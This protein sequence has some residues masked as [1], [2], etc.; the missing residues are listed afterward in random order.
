MPNIN[1]TDVAAVHHAERIIR[2]QLDRPG[3][4][5]PDDAAEMTVA[6]FTASFERRGGLRRVVLAGGWEVDPAAHVVTP[7]RVPA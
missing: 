5:C 6:G 3:S 7:V 2:D 1:R 4:L